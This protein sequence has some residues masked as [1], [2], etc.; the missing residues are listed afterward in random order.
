MTKDANYVFS[1]GKE[2]EERLLRLNDFCNPYSFQFLKNNG[3][4]KGNH[5]IDIGCGIGE[6]TCWLA[7]QVGPEGHVTAIDISIEQLE[8]A[9]ARARERRLNNIE[10]I[11]MSIYDLVQLNQ[12][13]DLVYSRFVL[14][15][16]V[17][18]KEAL[19]AMRDVARPK[20]VFCLECAAFG[21]E[22]S[23]SYPENNAYTKHLEW[24]NKLRNTIVRHTDIGMKL[25]GFLK[26]VGLT[27]INLGLVQPVFNTVYQREH[28]VLLTQECANSYQQHHIA[29]AEEITALISE[30]KQ[31]VKNDNIQLAFLLMSQVSARK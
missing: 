2:F 28:C 5:V 3:L 26:E 18:P 4:K 23:F 24:F 13:Y 25:P 15:H 21:I 20:A 12:T 29:T 16:V 10:F 11:E 6:L 14:D 7:E 8:L 9:K 1:V 31:L 17:S 19:Q 30:L 27:E 22:T